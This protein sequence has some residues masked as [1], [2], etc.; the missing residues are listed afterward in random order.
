MTTT[1][2]SAGTHAAPPNNYQSEALEVMAAMARH[3]YSARAT[4]ALLVGRRFVTHVDSLTLAVF[5]AERIAAAAQVRYSIGAFDVGEGRS[6]R[7]G[8][9][10]FWTRGQRLLDEA[11]PRCA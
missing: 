8:G 6:R 10:P 3:G 1:K 4:A 7:R 2:V 11:V 5:E 9:N